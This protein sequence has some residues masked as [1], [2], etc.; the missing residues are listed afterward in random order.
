MMSLMTKL[1]QRRKF[2][3]TLLPYILAFLSMEQAFPNHIK[4]L[5]YNMEFWWAKAYARMMS[6]IFVILI[7]SSGMPILYFV[8]TMW[9]AATYLCNKLLIIYFY[10][11]ITTFNRI[12]PQFSVKFL[13]AAL[14]CHMIGASFMLTNPESFETFNK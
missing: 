1:S 12:I 7:Y 13:K 3:L 6:T 14:V 9:F 10:Q 5:K 8:G 2:K 4:I 11:S